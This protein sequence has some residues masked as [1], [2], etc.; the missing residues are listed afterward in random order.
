MVEE[1]GLI[2]VRNDGNRHLADSEQVHHI[3]L[4]GLESKL[5][6]YL[7]INKLQ[8]IGVDVFGFSGLLNDRGGIDDI[9]IRNRIGFGLHGYLPSPWRLTGCWFP[10]VSNADN[11]SVTS[12]PT[13]HQV[14]H[15]PHPTQPD[16]PN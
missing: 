13:G 15:R 12:I 9:G 11:S 1:L 6:P 2:R 8:T 4:T 3:E 10:G 16:M 7:F 5:T 14:I